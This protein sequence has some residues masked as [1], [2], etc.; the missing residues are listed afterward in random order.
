VIRVML[1]CLGRALLLVALLLL[2]ILVATLAAAHL[3]GS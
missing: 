3:A 2:L 1:G